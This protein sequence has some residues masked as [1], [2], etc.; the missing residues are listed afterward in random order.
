MASTKL[1]PSLNW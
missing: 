1:F